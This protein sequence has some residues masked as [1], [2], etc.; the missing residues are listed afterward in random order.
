MFPTKAPGLDGL[1]AHFY[2]KH[3]DLCGSE[4]TSAVLSILNGGETPESINQTVL[5]PIPKVPHP[6]SLA[7]FRPI[8]L[9]NV[10]LKIVSKAQANRL[11]EILP[12]I[13]SD[14]QLAFVP[15]R[16]ITDNIITASECL[17]FMKK[18]RSRNQQ[19]CALKL[20]M[21]KA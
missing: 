15:G 14:E 4:V 21:M 13:I 10:I 16:L 12:E 7:Q 18:K 19:F 11:K 9:C 5:V 3:W 6:T 8:S 2:Q 20:D 1:P 17:H